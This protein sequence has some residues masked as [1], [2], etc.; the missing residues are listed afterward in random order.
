M[1]NGYLF[2]II[3]SDFHFNRLQ[4]G[5]GIYLVD[6]DSQKISITNKKN[7]G[8]LIFPTQLR[9]MPQDGSS[10]IE[11]AV[12][13]ALLYCFIKTKR[14]YNIYECYEVKINEHDKLILK[15][16]KSI[17]FFEKYGWAIWSY[18]N[19]L[20][21]TDRYN[22][23]TKDLLQVLRKGRRHFKNYFYLHTSQLHPSLKT[24]LGVAMSTFVAAFA[25]DGTDD[26]KFI[27]VL[28]AL[29]ALFSVSSSEVTFRLSSNVAWFMYPKLS[30]YN[31]RR[32]KFEE[33]KKLYNVR[34]QIIHG[35]YREIKPDEYDSI[36]DLFSNIIQ[37]ILEKYKIHHIFLNKE[38]HLE[39]IKK[40]EF[41][42]LD[43]LL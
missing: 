37:M 8:I 19:F 13:I 15:Y 9:D 3:K 17:N 29:E 33:I 41:G 6:I 42:Y 18:N 2:P 10:Y 32:M 7:V 11:K 12:D 39:F 43:T 25:N 5:D 16:K 36:L 1:N 14:S 21:G 24:P 31:N 27:L 20:F 22:V 35:R 30:E 26:P 23:L 34:S 38:K 4:I 40:L 28:T